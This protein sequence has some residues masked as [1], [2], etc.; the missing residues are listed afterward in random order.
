L[1]ADNLLNSTVINAIVNM[2]R[3]TLLKPGLAQIAVAGLVFPKSVNAGYPSKAFR[4]K[5]ASEAL[6]ELYVSADIAS[7][8]QIEIEIPAVTEGDMVPV[9]IKSGFDNTESIAVIVESNPSPFTAYFRLYE[10]QAYVS[11]ESG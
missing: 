8:N 10:P 6:G 5:Q 1:A 11:P 3:R 7:S 2:Q 9:K 4:T